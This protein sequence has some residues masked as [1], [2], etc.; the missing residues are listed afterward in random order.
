[1]PRPVEQATEGVQTRLHRDLATPGIAASIP[2]IDLAIPGIGNP[3]GSSPISKTPE[4]RSY[5]C[6]AT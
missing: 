4:S 5:A 2:G 1:M 3:H 6:I